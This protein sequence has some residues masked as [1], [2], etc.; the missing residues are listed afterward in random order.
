[1]PRSASYPTDLLES[2]RPLLRDGLKRE[3]GGFVGASKPR[4]LISERLALQLV[5]SGIAI[6]VGNQL[7]S[8]EMVAALPIADAQGLP[9]ADAAARSARD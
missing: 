4:T 2:L 8:P 9:E 5:A 7:L 6:L 1:M 3:G